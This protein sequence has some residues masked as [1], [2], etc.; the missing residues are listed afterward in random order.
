MR[1]PERPLCLAHA[2]LAVM[3]AWTAWVHA[4]PS[5]FVKSALYVIIAQCYAREKR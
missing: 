4:R 3:T 1:T 5:D 2:V